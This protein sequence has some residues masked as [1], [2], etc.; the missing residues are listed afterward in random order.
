MVER[1]CRDLDKLESWAITNH[2]K[3]NKTKNRIVHPGR[4]NPVYT[5]RLGDE[6]PESSPTERDLGVLVDSKLNMSLPGQPR[7]PIIS[8]VHQVWN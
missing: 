2:M 1:P 4:G 6:M 7:R 8:R 5:Y 3:F